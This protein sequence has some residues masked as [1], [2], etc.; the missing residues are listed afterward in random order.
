M[1]SFVSRIQV[2]ERIKI[3]KDIFDSLKLNVGDRVKVTLEKFT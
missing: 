1:V 3:P 2:G